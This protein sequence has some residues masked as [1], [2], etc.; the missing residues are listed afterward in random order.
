[1][2]ALTTINGFWSLEKRKE[3]I[4]WTTAGQKLKNKDF[5]RQEI[6]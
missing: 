1:M 5:S 4:S 2:T 3:N 6:S